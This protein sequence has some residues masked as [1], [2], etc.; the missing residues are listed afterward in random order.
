MRKK[1]KQRMIKLLYALM[2]NSR[3]SDRSLAKT[4]GVSQ[5]TVTR[6]RQRLEEYGYVQ[7][8]TVIPDLAKIG[9]E[10]IAVSTMNT[11]SHNPETGETNPELNEEIHN[12]I[13]ENSKIVFAASGD[14]KDGK[15]ALITSV[16][17]DFTEFSRFIFDFRQKWGSHVS[18]V[19]TFLIPVKDI[20]LKHFTFKDL[21]QI[22]S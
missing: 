14:G 19:E 10:V 21:S 20:K 22:Q 1:T 4:M 8:Y 13:A 18:E 11:T 16:H 9:F 7:E 2:K 5:P 15:N 17:K 12:W 3:R 6:M